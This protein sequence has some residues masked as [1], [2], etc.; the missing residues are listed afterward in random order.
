MGDSTLVKATVYYGEGNTKFTSSNTKVATVNSTGIVKAKKAGA[1]IITA[2]NN[3]KSA[4]VKITIKKK[5]NPM[6]VKAKTVSAKSKKT[7]TIKKAK[8]FTIKNAKGTVSFKK[9]SGNKKI[10]INKK[11]G[12]ITVKK[13]LKKGTYKFKVKVTAAGNTTYKPKSKTVIV[14][15]NVQK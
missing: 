13:G 6:T 14:K 11:K 9:V 4:T 2:T 8:A 10:S 5:N 7:T 12:N 1:V 3:G 15:I